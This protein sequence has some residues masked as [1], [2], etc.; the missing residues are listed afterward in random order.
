MPLR[1]DFLTLFYLK[2]KWKLNSYLSI[3]ID[4]GQHFY[5]IITNK[6]PY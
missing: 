3:I 1:A 4:R 5:D 2:L 6:S